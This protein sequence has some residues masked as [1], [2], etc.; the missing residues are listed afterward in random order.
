M[1]CYAGSRMKLGKYLLCCLILTAAAWAQFETSAVLG[2]VN[3]RTDRVIGDAKVTLT[4][5][6][7]NISVSRQTDGNGGFEFGNVKP[8]RYRLTAEKT[9]FSNAVAENFQVNVTARQRVDLTMSVGQVLESVEVTAAVALVE[10]D[11]SQRGQVIEEKKIVELPLNGRNYADLALLSAGVRRSSYA[12]ANPPREAS[13]NVNGQRA[14][15]NNFLLDGVDN[16]AYGTSNQGFSSQVVNLPPDAIQEF[17]IVT[18][19]M[20]AEYGRTSGAVINAAMKSG[21]NGFHGALWE[22]L[23]NDKLNAIG[24]FPPP[25]GQKPTLKR[26]QYGFVFGGPIVRDRAFFFTDYE[27]F[28]ERTG[29][30]VTTNLPTANQRLGIG[31]AAV[32]NPLTGKT[33]PANT[34][35]PQRDYSPLARYILQNLPLPNS[36]ASAN[37]FVNLRADRNNTDKMDA[38]LDAQMSAKVTAFVRASHRKTNIFQSPEIPGLAG[39]GGNG[40]IR[41]LNQQLAF[42]ATWAPTVASLFEFRM[43]FSKTRAGKEPPS[44]GG[45]SMRDLFGITGLSEDPRLTGG[46]TNQDVTGFTGFG[47]QS[48]NPQWQYPFLLNPRVNYSRIA[49]RHSFKAGYEYQHINTEVQDVNPLYGLDAYQGGFSGT[50]LADFIFGLRSRYSLTN[51]FIAQYRQMGNMA[52]LQDDWRVTS[53]LTLNLG[54]R[55]EYF[56]PQWEAD[57]RLTNYDPVSNKLI[58]A[59]SGSIENRS[60]VNPDR[61]NWAPRIGFAYAWNAKTAIHSGYGVSYVHFNRSGGGN[62]LAINGP[63]VVNA[64]VNQNPLLPNGQVNPAF[65]TTDQ[66]YPAGLTEPANFN[67]RASNISY[68]PRDTR[69]GYVQ[70]WFFSIQREILS[71]TVFD[72]AYVGNRS[73]KLVLFADYNQARPQM[74]PTENAPLQARRPIQEFAAITITCPCGWANYHALQ[75]KL[76]RR[77]TAGL[78]FLNSITWSKAMDNVGQALEDQGQGNRSS[79]QNFYDLRAEKGAS[80]FDQRLN[81]TTSIIWDV[82]LGRGRR[83][84]SGMAA[85]LDYLI[86]GWQISGINTATSGEPLNI[87]WTPPATAQVSDIGPDWRGAISYRPNLIGT[88]VIPESARSGTIRYLDRAAFAATTATMPFGNLGRNA[89]YGPSFLQLDANIRKS[90]RLSERMNLQ[91]RSEFFNMLNKTNFR[92]PVVNWSASTFGQFTQTY[93]PRQIQFALKLIF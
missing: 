86:G 32:T 48:T 40:F 81:N 65:R 14:T 4:S 46:I 71:N 59:T 69:T 90:F 67:P 89:I 20:S 72:I 49:G 45:P 68:I 42:G 75:A 83:F 8:G 91:F 54:V 58:P 34:P 52:Y 15:F 41:I 76:E 64:I 13:F 80:G 30:L 36:S 16:N 11:S 3:D 17:R 73:N 39:G 63:Q 47:R 18:N 79:P 50:P 43:G 56:T 55:Y 26:N 31:P 33:Y 28:R 5:L 85:P 25:G 23:R 57:N 77:F 38:K 21:S 66:G 1:C 84:G 74:S 2:T 24:F 78:S 7:T 93:Q 70:N 12:V 27:G 92:A 9:G 29:F 35:I 82:P 62:L 19:N 61:N 22:F 53:K 87:G 88:A 51:F 10:S 6:E 60:Q 44:I 37:Q